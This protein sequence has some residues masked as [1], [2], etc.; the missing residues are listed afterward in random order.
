MS[1]ADYEP[2]IGLEVH[3]QLETASK[4]FSACPVGLL[5]PPNTLV[6]AYTLGLPGTLPVPNARAVHHG[7]ALALACGCQLHERSRF[8][9][10]HYFYPDLPKGYQITQAHEPYATGGSLE[11]PGF[12]DAE[13]RPKRVPLVRIHFEEDAGKN[14]HVPGE[15]HSLIDYGRAGAPLLEIVSE[16]TIGSPEEAA[17]YLRELRTLVRT[18]GISQANMEEG[19]LRCD[20]NVSVRRRGSTALGVRCEIKNL[21]SFRFLAQAIAAEIRRQI[22][23]LEQGQVIESV[24]LSYDVERDRTRVMRSKEDAADYRYLPEPDLP[25]LWIS[26][27]WIDRVRSELPPLPAARRAGYLAQGISE[28]DAVLLASE[29]ALGDYLDRTLAAGA[30]AKKA[31]NWLTVEL[32]GKL[33]ADGIG[34]ERSPVTPEALAELIAMVEAD[35]VSGRAAKAIFASLYGELR[36]S[37]GSTPPLTPRTIAERDG[38]RQVSDA[39]VLEAAVREVLAGHPEQV[40]QFRAGKTKVR[41]FFVGQVMKKT[42]GQANPQVLG[43]LL[44]R[45]L[46]EDD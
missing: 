24:T 30:P 3:C 42:R 41:G 35:E 18:L 27:E 1:V 40:Q 39:G 45:L 37:E 13:G 6:D 46:G 38:H 29:P 5:A 19:T 23:L 33:N 16:P 11:V 8:A 43:E 15:D 31:S 14:V 34:I 25:P 36:E 9:R 2:V 26:S 20:A 17:A 28:D 12:R 21:N 7:I 32:L 44:D 4:M 22:D 10:K